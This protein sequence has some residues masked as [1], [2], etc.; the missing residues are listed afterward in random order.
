MVKG[1]VFTTPT[2][3]SS[4]QSLALYYLFSCITSFCH[5]TKQNLL[6]LVLGSLLHDIGKIAV[7]VEILTKPGSLTQ[8]EFS[9]IQMHPEIGRE[10]LRRLNIPAASILSIIASQH[11]EHMDGRGYPNHLPGSKMHKYSRM[12]AIADVY[13]ASSLTSRISRIKLCRAAQ[14]GSSTWGFWSFFSIM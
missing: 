13:D 5:L 6:D 3:L 9:V 11:H 12:V 4:P 1:V 10:K 8:T 2:R 14:W 7:P